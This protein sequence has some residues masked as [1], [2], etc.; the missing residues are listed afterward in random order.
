M[1]DIAW[2][3]LLHDFQLWFVDGLDHESLKM[4]LKEKTP[5]LTRTFTHL[6]DLLLV[7]VGGKAIFEQI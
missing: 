6:E 7:E 4:R 3:D 2:K 5:A 1:L